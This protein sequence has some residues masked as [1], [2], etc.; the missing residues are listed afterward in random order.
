[1]I[2]FEPTFYC[3]DFVD[4]IA[5]F[6]RHPSGGKD[7]NGK[8]N[9]EERSRNIQNDASLHIPQHEAEPAIDE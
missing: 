6:C 3:P 5:F 7:T 9:L 8:E 1:M 2:S 4:G